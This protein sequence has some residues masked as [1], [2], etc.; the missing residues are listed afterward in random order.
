[1][2]TLLF[3]EDP[4]KYKHSPASPLEVFNKMLSQEKNSLQPT[5]MLK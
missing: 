4:K 2:V 1:M 3:G 5:H